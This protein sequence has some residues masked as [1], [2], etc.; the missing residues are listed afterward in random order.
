VRDGH[1][2][3]QAANRVASKW[4][5]AWDGGDYRRAAVVA[6]RALKRSHT[7]SCALAADSELE[8][9]ALQIFFSALRDV[10]NLKLLSSVDEWLRIPTAVEVAWDLAHDAQERLQR[11]G[12]I[13][14]EFR[15]IL[16]ECIDKVIV[17]VNHVYGKGLYC[18]I[19]YVADA[20]D[21]T[22]CGQDTRFCDHVTGHWYGN[23]ICRSVPRNLVVEAVALVE[24]PRNPRCRIWP[25]TMNPKKSSFWARILQVSLVENG[26]SDGGTV[27]DLAD[28]I[29]AVKNVYRDKRRC[30]RYEVLAFRRLS[31]SEINEEVKSALQRAGI[32]PKRGDALKIYVRRK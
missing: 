25:W 16:C 28:C 26:P 30:V 21:C 9:Y 11:H 3:K 5:R 22:I 13:T 8:T 17:D 20:Y 12:G 6:Q 1:I 10:A 27:L 18:S 32:R 23:A 31:R 4:L 19:E 24:S 2:T 7:K 14:Q 15:K 29:P